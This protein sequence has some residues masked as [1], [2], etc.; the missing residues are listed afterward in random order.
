MAC[1]FPNPQSN[2]PGALP[3]SP[4]TTQTNQLHNGTSNTERSDHS[5]TDLVSQDWVQETVTAAEKDTRRQPWKKTFTNVVDSSFDDGEDLVKLEKING[6][7]PDPSCPFRIQG[8][9][10]AA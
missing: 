3:N 4:V 6:G 10:L 2:M 1:K 5:I 7:V 8:S 9:S